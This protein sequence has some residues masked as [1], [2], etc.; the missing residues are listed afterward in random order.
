VIMTPR[1]KI[2]TV[3]EVTTLKE[4][5]EVMREINVRHLPVVEKGVLVGIISIKD[6]ASHLDLLVD[7]LELFITGYH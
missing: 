4:C 2:S 7:N 1:S 6:I 5:L 3:T